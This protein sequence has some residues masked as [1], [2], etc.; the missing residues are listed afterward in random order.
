MISGDN[1]FGHMSKYYEKQGSPMRQSLANNKHY[2]EP[3]TNFKQIT[4]QESS[5]NPFVSNIN[6][7]YTKHVEGTQKPN[8]KMR[9]LAT[10]AQQKQNEITVGRFKEKLFLRGVKGL[11]GLKR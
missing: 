8:E 7:Q 5:S 11:I 3:E 4:G 9:P 10:L 2:K 1:P 6:T